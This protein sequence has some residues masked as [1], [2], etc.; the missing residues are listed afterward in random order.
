M[1]AKTIPQ[2]RQE[3]YR[4]ADL[5]LNMTSGSSLPARAKLLA[6]DAAPAEASET[7]FERFSTKM[8][9]LTELENRFRSLR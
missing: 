7:I 5:G 3:R 2:L 9:F 1:R 6:A 4:G 8:S